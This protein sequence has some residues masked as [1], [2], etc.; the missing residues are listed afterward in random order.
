MKNPVTPAGIQPATFRFVA[1]HLNH[2]ATA[3]PPGQVIYKQKHKISS[4]IILTILFTQHKSNSLCKIIRD[5][6]REMMCPVS[7]NQTAV[8]LDIRQELMITSN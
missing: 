7:G 2:C 3:V 8:Q 4:D 6:D 5:A 1:Q